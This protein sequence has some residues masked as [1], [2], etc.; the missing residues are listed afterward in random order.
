MEMMAISIAY[1]QPVVATRVAWS[2]RYAVVL[3]QRTI[4]KA[5]GGGLL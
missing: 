4:D 1:D 3:P 2:G 5:R